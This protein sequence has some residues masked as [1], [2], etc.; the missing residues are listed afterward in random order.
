MRIS[1][2]ICDRADYFVETENAYTQKGMINNNISAT[3]K[4]LI[5][6][7]NTQDEEEIVIAGNN[8]NSIKKKS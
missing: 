6:A 5:Y 4:E 1:N 3:D 7:E 2:C 8:V